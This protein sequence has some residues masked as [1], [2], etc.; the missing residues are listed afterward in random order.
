MFVF[1]QTSNFVSQKKHKT[2]NCKHLVSIQYINI[3]K[4][5]ELLYMK[6]YKTT[7]FTT[8]KKKPHK[9]LYKQAAN[10]DRT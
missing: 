2:T 4:T 3:T 8:I 7:A 5:I 1:M 6:N 10:A 9:A